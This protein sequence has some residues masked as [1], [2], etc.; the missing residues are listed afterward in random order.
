MKR[1][2]QL[3]ERESPARRIAPTKLPAEGVWTLDPAGQTQ[4]LHSSLAV[5]TPG[6]HSYRREYLAAKTQMLE[7]E[8]SK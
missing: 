6:P 2:P 5:H 1:Y 7:V 4:H 3:G 8:P